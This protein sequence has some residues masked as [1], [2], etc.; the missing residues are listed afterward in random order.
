M[1]TRFVPSPVENASN[2]VEH[3]YSGPLY[4]PTVAAM[5]A[6][7]PAGPLMI[8]VV[9]LY[10][11]PD[12]SSF[13]AFGRVFSG[14]VRAGDTV[15][16]LGENYTT[17]DEEDMAVRSVASLSISQARYRV[18]VTRAVAGNVILLEGVD[19]SIIKSATITGNSG[20]RVSSLLLFRWSC[21]DVTC[22]CTV[23]DDVEIFKPFVFFSA[24]VVKLAVEPLNP[25]ELPKVLTGLRKV[26]SLHCLSSRIRYHQR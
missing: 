9:K 7:N 12:G 17:T 18:D 15:R 3:I 14:T 19:E 20:M 11:T 25:S 21:I 22:D 8:N 4:G 2:K 23:D 26:V 5:R 13:L 10:P 24:S 16:V 1:V 6:C